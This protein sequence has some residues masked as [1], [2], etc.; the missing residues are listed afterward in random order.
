[1]NRILIMPDSFKGTI[2]SSDVCDI[3]ED[4]IKRAQPDVQTIKYP[5]AD[6]GEGTVDCFLSFEDSSEKVTRTVSGPFGED[7]EAS[8][9][10]FDQTAVIEMCA[11]AGLNISERLDPLNSSTYGVGQLIRDAVKNGSKKIVLGLGGSCTNDAGAGMAVALGVKFYDDAGCE[12]IPTGGTLEKVERI[13]AEGISS[14]LE[15]VSVFAMCDI[16]NPIC[17]PKGATYIFAPQKGATDETLPVLERN[18]KRFVGKIKSELGVDLSR[19]VGGGAAGGLGGGAY[20]FLNA[21]LQRGIDVILDIIGFEEKLKD[22]SLI[23]T[24]EGKIDNQTLNGKVVMGIAERAK[25]QN[26]PVIVVSGTK[27]DD[28]PDL[29]EFGIM[30]LFVTSKEGIPSSIAK[31]QVAAYSKGKLRASMIDV[32]KYIASYSLKM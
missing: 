22:C 6:G 28:L 31:E 11:A 20:A 13:D 5:I 9:A 7:V 15:G 2:T 8:Y 29:R 26:V 16:N 17:G 21:K 3:I 32:G 24:G 4:G 18:M 30:K 25:L 19:I 12:F 27:A 10:R 14:L 1:M 23:I